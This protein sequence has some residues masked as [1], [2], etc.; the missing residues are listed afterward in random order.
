M[1]NLKTGEMDT[2]H[3]TNPVP[4]IIAGKNYKKGKRLRKSK[5]LSSV[6][7][8]ILDIFQIDKPKEMS[9]KSLLV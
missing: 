5:S 4:F 7:P 9:S 1:V 8:T 3:S 6:A 2:K